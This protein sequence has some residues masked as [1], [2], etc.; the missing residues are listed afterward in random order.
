MLSSVVA[1]CHPEEN[2]V[3]EQQKN[4]HENLQFIIFHFKIR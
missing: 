3:V 1:S 2:S 4:W